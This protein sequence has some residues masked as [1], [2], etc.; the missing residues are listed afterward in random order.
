MELVNSTRMIAGYT[1]GMEPSGRGLL[2]VAVKGTFQI[3]SNGEAVG[4]AEEQEPLVMA[5]TFSGDPRYR[6]L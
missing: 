1:I 3:P 5:D 2:V 6:P 4:L